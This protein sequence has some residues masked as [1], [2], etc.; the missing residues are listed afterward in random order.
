M[1][2]IARLYSNEN[3][4]LDIVNKLRHLGHD[5]LTSY[6]AKQANQGIPDDDV[7]KF[8]HQQE[9]A[10]I[11]LNRQDFIQLH[12]LVK[13]HSGI[14]LCKE[15]QGDDDYQQQAL[16]IHELILEVS[17]LKSR[18][19]RV[20]KQNFKGCKTQIFIYKEVTNA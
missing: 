1:M 14:I 19:F 15:C 6:D 7:L 5:V 11:T 2:K 10:V 17:E 9:R 20:K 3:F 12:K 13:E 4:P 16:K 8:A 18:L